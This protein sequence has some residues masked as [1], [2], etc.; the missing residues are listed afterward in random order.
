MTI[1]EHVLLAPYT[2]FKI[3]GPARYFAEVTRDEEVRDA[4]VFAH[5]HNLPLFV[6]GG[7]SNVLISDQGFPGLV[8]AMRNT[9]ITWIPDDACVH[10][11]SA[12]GVEWDQFVS[13]CVSH[14]YFGLENLSAIPGSVG[15][16][17]VQN[18]GAYGVE[19]ASVVEWVEVYDFAIDSVRRI[20]SNALTFGYRN[21]IFK[22][23]H[24]K[25][26]VVLRVSF[27]LN[28]HGVL[29]RN[30]KDIA[31]YDRNVKHIETL[32]DMREAIISVRSKKFPDLAE[33][34]T[35]GSFFKN[36]IVERAIAER[37]IA[38]YPEAPHYDMGEGKTKLS[39]AWI[40]DHVLAMRGVHEGHVSTWD[41]QAL[42][43]VS[44]LH[45]SAKDISQFTSR[46][47]DTCYAK[48]KIILE[49]EVVFVG[50][51]HHQ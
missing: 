7:G 13:E 22:S 28:P 36:P 48:T 40:I 34:G 24:E 19:V 47:I 21:S 32:S 50:D 12:A 5:S 8:I 49:P 17:V 39:A 6:L 16:S 9:D 26:L 20:E 43:V 38:E 42:V 44:D 30:Y 14:G 3:G 51:M 33:H 23:E 31:E 10:V 15:A 35:A 2:T 46:I 37:F 25:E 41:A 27:R 18:I 1:R 4:V 29:A 45:A 11:V